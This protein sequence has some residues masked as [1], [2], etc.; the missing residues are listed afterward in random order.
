VCNCHLGIWV[1][2]TADVY[3]GGKF[4][5]LKAELNP[6]RHLLALVGAHHILQVSRIRVKCAT[7]DVE[8]SGGVAPSSVLDC[9]ELLA[10][11]LNLLAVINCPRHP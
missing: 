4:N 3:F 9:G 2:S 5:P 7:I 10:I 1:G 6:I 8:R 11:F